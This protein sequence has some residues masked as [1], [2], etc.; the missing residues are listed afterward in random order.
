MT[1]EKQLASANYVV[2]HFDG[3]PWVVA[4]AGGSYPSP[5]A[6]S[7]AELVISCPA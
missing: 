5:L 3:L 6:L 2:G 1:R 4:Q 7:Q